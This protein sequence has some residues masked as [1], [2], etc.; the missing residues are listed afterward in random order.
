LTDVSLRQLKRSAKRGHD[1]L[2]SEVPSTPDSS[3]W[4]NKVFLKERS[5]IDGYAVAEERRSGRTTVVSFT[6]MEVLLGNKG[7]V[8][9]E[10]KSPTGKDGGFL[11][12]SDQV[13]MHR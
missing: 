1:F 5:T 10:N 12:S 4:S 9:G 8:D 7:G 3:N 2:N 6:V 11:S 13:M